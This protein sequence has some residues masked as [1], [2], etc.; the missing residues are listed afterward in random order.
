MHGREARDWDYN[1]G[2]GEGPAAPPPVGMDWGLPQAPPT[3]ARP[4]R[5]P[6]GRATWRMGS[7]PPAVVAVRPGEPIG[8]LSGPG[9]RPPPAPQG[10][11]LCLRRAGLCPDPHLRR[12]NTAVR[13]GDAPSRGCVPMRGVPG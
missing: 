10:P 7:G 6:A 3:R 12:P 5:A 2:G 8:G 4:T 13:V 9:P 11:P 1:L